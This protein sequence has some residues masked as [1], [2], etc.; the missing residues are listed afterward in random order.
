MHRT[1]TIIC[2]GAMLWDVIGYSVARLEE[3][4]DVPG[5]ISREPGGVA[6]N[7]ATALARLGLRPAILSAVGRNAPGEL[8]LRAVERKGV[9]IGWV[10]REG[11]QNPDMYLA[12][13]SPN[14]L[15]A[16]IADTRGLEAAGA[17][18]LSPLRDGRLGSAQ[19]P[20]V[21]TMV[22]DGNLNQ[23]TISVIA[24][25]PAFGRASLR[26][27]AASPDKAARLW[28]LLTGGTTTFH[29]N[30]AEAEAL[31]GR[32]FRSAAR[33]AEAVV[34]LGAQRAL[35][36][37]GANLVADA[38]RNDATLVQQPEAAPIRRVTGAGD[39]FLA[40]HLAAELAGAPRAEA[41]AD[42]SRAA[43]NHVAGAELT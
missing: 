14:G 30:L 43:A 29:L 25:D 2:I 34:A 5:R 40:A 4:N 23:S 36:T 11:G 22:V 41:L 3:G 21:G 33:A 15:F 26:A 24:R 6:L 20:F 12:I 27:V 35:V 31:T 8:L 17:A 1:T 39:V 42:A 10:W 18:I 32:S 19:D 7:V 9:D 38:L 28:P 13:E 37:D 16:A